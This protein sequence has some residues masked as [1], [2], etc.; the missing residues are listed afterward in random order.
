MV[1]G[2]GVPGFGG[3]EAGE[4]RGLGTLRRGLVVCRG[5]RSL[6]GC[7]GEVGVGLGGWSIRS[8]V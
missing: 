5:L 2:R 8:R 7:Y 1:E 6:G 4:S 3:A